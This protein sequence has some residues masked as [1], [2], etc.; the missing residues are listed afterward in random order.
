MVGAM[1]WA[2][3]GVFVLAMATSASARESAVYW[4]SNPVSPGE[5][6]MVVGAGLESTKQIAVVRLGDGA[7]GEPGTDALHALPV[8]ARPLEPAQVSELSVKFVLP[9][10]EKP[11]L[12]AAQMISGEERSEVVVLN[13]PDLRW[14]QGDAGPQATPGGWLRGFGVS[15]AEAGRTPV[16]LLKGQRMLRLKAQGDAYALRAALPKDLPAGNY[17]VF[18]HRGQGG[19]LGW[20]EGRPLRVVKKPKW[21]ERVYDVRTYGALGDGKAD[22]SEAVGKALEAIKQAGGGVLYFP[23][24]TYRISGTIELPRFTALRGEGTELTVLNWPDRPDPLPV[25]VRGTNSFAVEQITLYAA[26]HYH[27]IVGDLGDQPEAGNVAL[28]GVRVRANMYR[29]EAGPDGYS[30][31]ASKEDAAKRFEAAGWTGAGPDTVRLGG[32]N[33]EITDCDLYGSGARS[34]FLSRV[35]GGLVARNTFTNGR[36]GWYLIGGSDGLIFED[37][38]IRGGDLM[39]TGGGLSTLDGSTSSRDVYFAHNTLRDFWGL[40]REAMTTDGPDGTFL[41]PIAGVAGPTLTLPNEPNWTAG[42]RRADDWKGA[43]VFLVAGHGAGQ[44]RRIASYEGNRVT[45]ERPFAIAPD[46][47]TTASITPLQE[48]YLLIGNHISDAGIAVQLFGISMNAVIAENRS[49]RAG[50]FRNWALNYYNASVQP[51]WYT[52]YLDN[53][54]TEATPWA[55]SHLAVISSSQGGYTGPLARFVVMRRNILRNNS[56]IEVQGPATDVLIENNRIEHSA[57]GISISND[58]LLCGDEF[59]DATGKASGVLLRRNRFLRVE[60]PLV[61]DGVGNAAVVR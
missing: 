10:E 14:V 28:R 17:Q 50:G 13:R 36:W 8:G 45:L 24:G 6:A 27:V 61:G 40:D 19:K 21:P 5:T 3:T 1:A 52:Q 20:S 48:N 44:Y 60:Q 51:T 7:A 32:A 41:G 18:V 37:N 30:G 53:E 11:G 55:D 16:V 54:I 25:L 23:R 34:L 59:K 33:V 15:L 47:T 4:S 38:V 58:I 35:R 56:R 29:R 57:V 49:V 39:S 42:G 43:G 12:Y 26:N 2:A 46:S 31:V 9:G 22:D